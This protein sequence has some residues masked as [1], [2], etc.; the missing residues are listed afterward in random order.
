[1]QDKLETELWIDFKVI[2]FLPQIYLQYH[3]GQVLCQSQQPLMQQDDY[4]YPG[5]HMVTKGLT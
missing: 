3:S 4:L 5:M 2:F 1:M